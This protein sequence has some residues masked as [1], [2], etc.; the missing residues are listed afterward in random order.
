MSGDLANDGINVAPLKIV[1][2]Y[3]HKVTTQYSEFFL[4][5][6]INVRLGAAAWRCQTYQ[7]LSHFLFPGSPLQSC[8]RGTNQTPDDSTIS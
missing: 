6:A 1:A 2:R 5:S 8:S 3:I 4:P 7:T